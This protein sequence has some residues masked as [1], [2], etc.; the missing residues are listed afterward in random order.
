MA[1]KDTPIFSWSRDWLGPAVL[2][3]LLGA[4]G[5]YVFELLGSA[6]LHSLLEEN[7]VSES[8]AW[9][10]PGVR[11]IFGWVLPISIAVLAIATFYLKG[12]KQ[13]RIDRRV[14]SAMQNMALLHG[15]IDE[16]GLLEAKDSGQ[17]FNL[18]RCW[19]C[20]HPRFQRPPTDGGLNE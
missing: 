12:V 16:D 1:K 13:G 15:H 7:P 5:K 9:A 2:L 19:R 17:S 14:D 20:G 3:A 10:V 4:V 8:L 11:F 6:F 18:E